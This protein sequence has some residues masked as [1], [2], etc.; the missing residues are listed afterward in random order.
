M[1]V[2]A[3]EVVIALANLASQGVY[4]EV[5]PAG[6]RSMNEIF[7]KAAELINDLEADEA[8]EASLKDETAANEIGG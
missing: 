3:S 6:A 2:K 1:K 8:A 7:D 5:S 4:K